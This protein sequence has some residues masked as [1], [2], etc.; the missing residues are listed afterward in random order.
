M[1]TTSADESLYTGITVCAF[2]GSETP[3]CFLLCF[4]RSDVPF[5]LIV[6]ERNSFI[7]SKCQHSVAMFD[8]AVQQAECFAPCSTS[9]F[10][11]LAVL[12][13]VAEGMMAV[14]ELKIGAV[15]VVNSPSF[16]P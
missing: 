13:R 14:L 9:P 12:W 2:G 3:C 1:L 4:D 6:T 10:F 7:F 16:D 11:L 15:T 5:C 8:Q